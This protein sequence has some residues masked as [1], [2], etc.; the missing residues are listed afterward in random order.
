MKYT[1][2]LQERKMISSVEILDEKSQI[3]FSECPKKHSTC[4]H[5]WY[6]S[7]ISQPASVIFDQQRNRPYPDRF[8]PPFLQAPTPSNHHSPSHNPSNHQLAAP[9]SNSRDQGVPFKRFVTFSSKLSP[10]EGVTIALAILL[11]AVEM[12]RDQ[13]ATA[14]HFPSAVEKHTA[15]D[16]HRNHHHDPSKYAL[17]DHVPHSHHGEIE[18]G[19]SSRASLLHC[20]YRTVLPLLALPH[21]SSSKP[22]H[23]AALSLC[24]HGPYKPHE[25]EPSHSNVARR[26][27]VWYNRRVRMQCFGLLLNQPFRVQ[28]WAVLLH[29]N[30]RKDALTLKQRT[31]LLLV[32]KHATSRTMFEQHLHSLQTLVAVESQCLE[33]FCPQS[34]LL[35]P[36]ER[37]PDENQF[38]S[39]CSRSIDVREHQSA[40]SRMVLSKDSHHGRQKLSISQVIC[41]D[42]VLHA[43]LNRHFLEKFLHTLFFRVKDLSDQ[44]QLEFIN[45]YGLILNGTMTPYEGS[46]C[47][48]NAIRVREVQ[49]LT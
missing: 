19:T 18:I 28:L 48:T 38:L 5:V 36:D 32:G 29:L 40:E 2:E 13:P 39:G 16:G 44:R 12:L 11:T 27:M 10:L 6:V 22:D 31:I 8:Y 30:Q 7:T 3:S 41:R 20:T 34:A 49:A 1:H 37:A 15:F 24:P 17:V 23:P 33:G 14:L 21:I 45:P 25:D 47:R 9:V 26:L 43:P 42:A 35:S 46:I 4:N